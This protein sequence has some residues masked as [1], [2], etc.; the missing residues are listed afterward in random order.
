M[1]ASASSFVAALALAV[2]HLVAGR[3]R[4]LERVPRSRWLSAASGVAV[5]YVFVHILPDLAEA[6]RDVAD[7]PA[8][9][10][11]LLEH[12]A[13][14]VALAGL[15]TFYGLER[16]AQT[17]RA[18]HRAAD[19]RDATTLRTFWVSIGSYAAYNALVGYLLLERAHAGPRELGLFTLAAGVHFVVNDSGLADHHDDAYENVGR[20]IVGAAP[21]AGWAVAT[22]VDVSAAGVAVLFA[23]LAGGIVANVLKEELPQ[24]RESR[25]WPFAAAAAAYAAI[26]VAI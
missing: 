24:E 13:Y 3:L 19:G 15:A 22:Q 1:G 4:L 23:F 10:A 12:E 5:A 2:V 11:E 14:L 6:Q 25:F 9:I 16:V 18:R 8:P 26:L 20:W 7:A 17:S 21:L